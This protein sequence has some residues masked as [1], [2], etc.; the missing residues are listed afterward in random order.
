VDEDVDP[1][2]AEAVNWAMSYRMQPYR[3][4]EIRE[5]ALSLGLDFSI[6]PPDSRRDVASMKSSAILIDA[7]CKWA[8][9]PTS[10]PQRPFMEKAQSIWEKLGLPELKLKS[11]WFGINL[12]SWRPEDIEDAQR[13][14]KGEHYRTG[15]IRE[16]QRVKLKNPNE[17]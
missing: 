16:G 7:T 12:G 6:A 8:Y 17:K 11:P 5:T 13:A 15:E 10:L 9:P 2:D 1:R 3:D 14:M 4:I